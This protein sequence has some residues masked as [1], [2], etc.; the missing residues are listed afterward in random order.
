MS[1]IC[2]KLQV[3]QGIIS[4][5]ESIY[6]IPIRAR[7][8]D[9][10]EVLVENQGRICYG[11]GIDETKGLGKNV[12][13]G[14]KQLVNWTN[15]AMEHLTGGK[16]SKYSQ[17]MRQNEEADEFDATLDIR[18]A[19]AGSVFVGNLTLKPDLKPLD[20]FVN[21]DGF[22]KGMVWVNRFNLGRYWPIV[23]PQVTLY[24]PGVL[25]KPY[26]ATN[27]FIVFELEEAPDSCYHTTNATSCSIDL[28][29]THIIDKPTPFKATNLLFKK[30]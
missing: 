18:N 25:L 8:N 7:Q 16:L 28:T 17:T 3:F 26:P 10:L 2:F 19:G 13:L 30:E 23:G 5:Q 21:L 12:S 9:W 11:G 27:E 29:D 15:I 14:G 20:T 1:K 4:R 22:S 24:L 6:S